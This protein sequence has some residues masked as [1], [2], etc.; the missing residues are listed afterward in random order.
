M[1]AKQYLSLNSNV[2]KY[3]IS[4]FFFAMSSSIVSF[5]I[6]ILNDLFDFTIMFKGI[7]YAIIMLLMIPSVIVG[8]KIA[9]NYSK[10]RVLL[11]VR[12]IMVLLFLV[13]GI[14]NNEYAKLLVI[15]CLMILIGVSNPALDAYVFE[16]SDEKKE[17]ESYSLI[18]F[19]RNI[20]GILT[21]IIT[22]YILYNKYNVFFLYATVAF[23]GIIFLANTKGEY[24]DELH[25]NKNKIIS[26]EISNKRI[27]FSKI[28]SI[29]VAISCLEFC[30]AQQSF[31]LPLL[32]EVE[33]GDAGTIMYGYI[34]SL[35][36]TILLVG[37]PIITLFLNKI[38]E[39]KG[40]IIS[41]ITC[42]WGFILVIPFIKSYLIVF[43]V[44][45]WSIGEVVYSITSMIYLK[46]IIPN[47]TGKATALLLVC[48]SVGIASCSF[49]SSYNIMYSNVS[50]W[51]ITSVISMI[52]CL[53][54]WVKSCNSNYK[55]QNNLS[56]NT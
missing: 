7:I 33:C 42:F 16:I 13:Y 18:Y 25:E 11:I 8:G 5:L 38:S 43:S 39:I 48:R 31:S 24:K 23:L 55:V 41:C 49:Y 10:K 52:A 46:S 21:P 53:I 37:T 22:A 17:K 1:I 30:Y 12:S 56:S 45:F 50:V 27:K 26:E 51:L 3:F 34:I 6:V 35:N 36:A 32:L 4:C 54:F 44:F 40:L 9:D 29:M 47:K 2:K 19:G 20:A 15:I 28:I 14:V